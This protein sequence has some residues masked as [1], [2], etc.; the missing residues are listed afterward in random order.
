MGIYVFNYRYLGFR[1]GTGVNLKKLFSLLLLLGFGYTSGLAQKYNIKTYSV[2][3]GLPSSQVYDVHI[4]D[5]GFVWFATTNGVVKYDGHEYELFDTDHGLK[6]ALIYDLYEDKDKDFWV[7]TEIGGVAKFED[8]TLI[9]IPELAWMDTIIVN[10]MINAPDGDLWFGTDKNGLI[11]WD[12]EANTFETIMESDGLPSNQIW[13]ILFDTEGV[14]WISTMYGVALYTNEQG[15]FRTYTQEK[16]QLSG[17]NT[18]QVYETTSGV[19]WIA[20]NE[21]ITKVDENGNISTLTEVNGERLGY[22][23]SVSQDDEGTVW[24]GTESNGLFWCDGGIYTH[25]TRRNGLSSNFIYRLIKA[26]D[27]TIWIATDGNGVSIFKDKQFI[28]YDSRSELGADFVSGMLKADDGTIWLGTENGLSSYKNG[29]FRNYTIP[30]EFFNENEIWDIEELPNGHLLLLTY[31]YEIIE[32]DGSEFFKPVFSDEVYPYYVSDI[33]AE[34][35]GDIWFAAFDALLK[36]SNG[37]LTKFDPPKGN[38][39]RTALTTLFRDSRGDLW[40]GTEGGVAR[41]DGMDFEFLNSNNKDLGKS[42]YQIT[43][44][45]KGN[46]WL[47][48]NKGITIVSGLNETGRPPEMLGFDLGEV[49]MDETMFIQFDSY[50]GLWHGTNAGINYYDLRNENMDGEINQM[51]F[52]LQDYGNGVEM[53]GAASLITEEGELWFGTASD[54]IVTFHF[55]N[56]K[57]EI[58][59][60]KPPSIFLRE[61]LANN[62]VVFDQLPGTRK[63]N[64][65]PL[66]L[67]YEQNNLELVFSGIDFK[68]PS[69][70]RYRYKLEGLDED[71]EQGGDLK[72]VRYTNLEPGTYEFKVSAK[73]IKSSWSLPQN[74]I[75]IKVRK[76]FWTSYWFY[77]LIALGIIGVVISYVNIRVNQLEKKNLKKQVDEKTKTLQDALN[78]KEVLIKEIHHRVKNNLAVVSGLLELQSWS[79]PDGHAKDAMQES[80]LRVLAM[81]KIHENLYQN[82]D[83]ARVNFKK[84]LEELIRSIAVTMRKTG[85][86]ITVFQYVDTVLLDVNIGIPVGLITNELVS[87]SYKHAFNKKGEGTITVTF[88]EKEDRYRLVVE[89]NGAGSD[90][91]ILEMAK[92]SL[93]M[94]LIKSLVSQINAEITFDGKNGAKFELNIYKRD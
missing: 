58:K 59:R 55:D 90:E 66:E 68:D 26:D 88:E 32:F 85:Q 18:Y 8:D 48:T 43:E 84:F 29:K 15:V 93:G 62:E 89:D 10:Y 2:N 5:L 38:Y 65:R 13:D 74:L 73:S 56:D 83:L 72:N 39:W 46:L 14:A 19:K 45:H 78:E 76:P 37:K 91:D 11:L 54:G 53:N 1:S 71:W 27:G 3:D 47:G 70:V 21:G 23:Y 77:A 94:N 36:F 6:D 31:N 75:T 44:D 28:F 67:E 49:Y 86:D 80:R 20:T 63:T 51:F 82:D 40:V 81:S 22:V 61:I 7:S 41:F 33:R 9:Y 50:G 30:K 16:D 64:T 87:N 79:M 92:G 12:K 42:I 4:D 17:E 35:N 60:T 34:E 57:G 52:P 25:I 24:I 69:R